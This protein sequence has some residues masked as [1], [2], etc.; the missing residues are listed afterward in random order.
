M[1]WGRAVL[2][3]AAF[4]NTSA[5]QILRPHTRFHPLC[6]LPILGK[7]V[8]KKRF[9]RMNSERVRGAADE[10]AELHGRERLVLTALFSW[11]WAAPRIRGNV[12]V[13]GSM[14]PQGLQTITEIPWGLLAVVGASGSCFSPAQSWAGGTPSRGQQ[15]RLCFLQMRLLLFHTMNI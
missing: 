8:Q 3:T 15:S 12:E 9:N 6:L 4:A 10:Y 2:F 13:S 5:L 7:T 11:N 1:W 14:G